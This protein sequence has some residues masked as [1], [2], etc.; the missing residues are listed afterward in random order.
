VGDRARWLRFNVYPTRTGA[1]VVVFDAAWN[2]GRPT[3]REHAR[4]DVA[5]DGGLSMD[6]PRAALLALSDALA[7]TADMFPEV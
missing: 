3:R 2:A 1:M 6:D 4:F 7:R 5:I